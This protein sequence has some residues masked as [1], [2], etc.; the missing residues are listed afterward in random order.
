MKRSKFNWE[1]IIKFIQEDKEER[2]LLVKWFVK[3]RLPMEEI[4]K[5]YDTS[6]NYMRDVVESVLTPA[7]YK[8][9]KH[10]RVKYGTRPTCPACCCE[11]QKVGK[12]KLKIVRE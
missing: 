9:A 6:T 7:E 2:E 8:A 3:D 10:E 11:F 4:S 12:L 5:F 1:Q